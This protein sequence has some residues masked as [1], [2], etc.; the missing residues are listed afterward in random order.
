MYSPMSKLRFLSL[1][2][3]IAVLFTFSSCNNEKEEDS[4]E[5]KNYIPS[6]SVYILQTDDLKS[7]LKRIDT[8][9]LVQENPHLLPREYLS[10]LQD[11]SEFTEGGPS[12][13]CFGK[14]GKGPFNFT[15][16]RK[17]QQSKMQLDSVQNKSLETFT[18]EEYQVHKYIIEDITT[19]TAFVDGIFIASNSRDQLEEILKPN[20]ASFLKNDVFNKIQAA[21]DPK[22]P[23]LFINHTYFDELYQNIFPSGIAPVNSLAEWSLVEMEFEINN[24]L[25]NGIAVSTE[26]SDHL[27]NI[28]TDVDSGPNETAKVTPV[29]SAGF[30]SF[31]YDQFILLHENLNKFRKSEDSLPGNHLL[32]YTSEAGV[33]FGND[34]RV[35]V[36]K[37]TDPDLAKEVLL[38]VQNNFREFRGVTIYSSE[39]IEEIPKLLNPL[40]QFSE[41]KYF[42]WLD[43]FIVLSEKPE[44]LESVISSYLN[45]S[46]LFEQDFYA[47]AFI[48]L[49]GNSSLLL[50][51]NSAE[52]KPP[53]KKAVS[54]EFEKEVEQLNLENYPLVALQFIQEKGFAHI[55]GVFNT[56]KNNSGN[57]IQQ[58]TSFTLDIN[59]AT[60][61]FLVK[62]HI[63]NQM[64]IAV[65]DEENTL[66]LYSSTGK[67]LWKK[68]L[69]SRVIGEV[70][71][72]DLFRNGNLQLAFTTLNSLHIIDRNGN[73][74]KPFPVKFKDDVT[75]PL[76]V[77]DYD[78]NRNY[79]FVIT[80]SQNILMYDKGGKIVKGFDPG[81]IGS[82]I[83]NA[84]KHIR[85]NNK[86][87][88]VFH[89]DDGKLH[90]VDRQ[91]R[92]RIAVNEKIEPSDNEWYD[93]EN[94]FVSTTSTGEIVF[95]N[96]AGNIE[97]GSSGVSALSAQNNVLVTL[98]EN[99]LTINEKA[100]ALDF[101][102]YTPPKIY[103]FNNKSYISVTDTQSQRLYLFDEKGNLIEGFPVYGSTE[104]EVFSVDGVN[105]ISVL[106]QEK[107]IILY[108][109]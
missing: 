72:V 8:L 66:H 109:F 9:S 87:F 74:V 108:R 18:F 65:Q 69:N 101:G 77:F 32:Q 80:Q 44:D 54:G 41:L 88:I 95:I 49:A 64:E 40:I 43:N 29:S 52:I 28:F 79:R 56:T 78:N 63:N 7:F 96:E 45:K 75:Q 73:P 92:S 105:Y 36:L 16:L 94:K 82:N 34:T 51:A 102:L 20:D 53:I 37:A 59:P 71:Q 81:K 85:F 90:I 83:N 100:I 89:E 91:G 19:Y 97:K 107:E 23:S 22:K 106:G 2:T 24:I 13:A 98:S 33:I 10:Q 103:F 11:L 57:S 76:Q 42:T 39:M 55:H 6:N 14:I 70:E 17:G 50:I 30:Y 47:D 46:T 35:M 31:T 4:Q 99:I 21:A 27:L 48:N 3:A 25:L 86:D 68:Q 58:L 61:G 93:F 15:Y 38:P 67:L 1:I 104:A 62:N 12:L 60:P 26:G 84:P 5:L